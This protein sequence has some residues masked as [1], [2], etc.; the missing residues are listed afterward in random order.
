MQPLF[1]VG[2]VHGHR[3]V[4]VR[5]LRETGL[6]DGTERWSGEDAVLWLLGD[7]LD[8]GPD[9]IG[10]ID[11]VRRLERESGGTVRCL[12]GNHEAFLLAVHAAG[13]EE[14]GFPGTTFADVWRANGGLPHDLQALTPEHRAWLVSRPAIAREGDWLLLHADTDAY[15][16]YGRS[17]ERVNAGI[18]S[19][20]GSGVPDALDEALEI[21]CDRLRLGDPVV[22]DTL[23]DVL[24]GSRIVHGH[25][26]VASVLGRD[27]RAIT[28]PLVSDDGRV[29]NVD[30]CL[31]GG[32]PGFVTRLD[33]IAA[34]GVSPARTA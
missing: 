3:D 25:T 24:G 14:T 27:P 7:L 20:L 16:R 30:H 34:L 2:D 6:V 11:L 8:R 1:V 21:L 28:G 13:D 26:P 5:L 15:L 17:V 32:G 4:L 33:E 31:F 10:S 23:L 19:A 29:V 22:V 12:L 18:A 9:G